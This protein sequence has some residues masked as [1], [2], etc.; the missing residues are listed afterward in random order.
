[1]RAAMEARHG[2]EFSRKAL[3]VLCLLERGV[4]EVELFDVLSINADVMQSLFELTC[5]EH[6]FEVLRHKVLTLLSD[7]RFFL[8]HTTER[9][10]R[11]VAWK[12]KQLRLALHKKSFG[13]KK[14]QT[15]PTQ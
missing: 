13:A 4:S 12:S 9:G 15:H 14:T 7:L 6:L 5:A 3:S 2:V 10:R 11:L 8:R 1:M